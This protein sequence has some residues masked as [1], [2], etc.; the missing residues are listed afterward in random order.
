[1]KNIKRMFLIDQVRIVKG[2]LG[3]WF[4]PPPPFFF[5]LAFLPPDTIPKSLTQNF[6]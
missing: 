6:F 5:F 4:L 3:L 2:V 1:M